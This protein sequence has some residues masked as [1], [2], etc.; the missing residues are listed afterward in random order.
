MRLERRTVWQACCDEGLRSA[1]NSLV[2]ALLEIPQVFLRCSLL[3]RLARLVTLRLAT[4]SKLFGALA[5]LMDHFRGLTTIGD[6]DS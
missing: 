5:C 3:G 6:H 2:I 4:A 1:P